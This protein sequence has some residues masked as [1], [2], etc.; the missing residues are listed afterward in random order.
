MTNGV[1]F[2]PSREWRRGV[3]VWLAEE[4][5]YVLLGEFFDELGFVW[6]EGEGEFFLFLLEL[7]DFFFYGVFAYHFVG[8]NGFVLSYSVGSV[9]G[10]LF[11]GGVPPRVNNIDVI[12]GGQIKS[13]SAGG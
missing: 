9:Y 10:L 13:Q 1:R 7:E 3:G 2:P 8:E 4:E 12:G 11:Y 5:F 6:D